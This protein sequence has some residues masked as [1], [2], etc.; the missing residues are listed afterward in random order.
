MTLANGR[1][2]WKAECRVSGSRTKKPPVTGCLSGTRR[3]PGGFHKLL[4][5]ALFV[6]MISAHVLAALYHQFVRKDGKL[7]R[8]LVPL[9]LRRRKA[10]A[11]RT[12]GSVMTFTAAQAPQRNAYD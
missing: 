3:I 4:G 2:G 7:R 6:A 12:S 11:S 5:K 9:N 1:V 10:L 8:I